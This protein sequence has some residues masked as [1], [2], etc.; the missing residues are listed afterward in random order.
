LLYDVPG[1]DSLK[2]SIHTSDRTNFKRCRQRWDFSSNIR[3]NLEPKK[4]IT[5]LWF[6]TGIHEALAAYYDPTTGEIEY[7]RNGQGILTKSEGRDPDYGIFVF[8]NFVGSWL[9]SLGEPGE[10]QILW[11][12][13]NLELGLG[14]LD[15]YFKWAPKNDDFE[16]I[17]VEREYKVG[18]PGLPGVSYSFRC[19]GLIKTK[20]H[21]WLLEHKTTAQFPDQ[22][23]WLMMDDQCGSY[24]WGLSQLD[25]PIFAEGVV[26]NELKKKTPQPLRPLL[27]GGYSINRSQDTSFDIALTTLRNEY[28]PIPKKYWD[29]L[30]FLKYKP[31]NFI[32]RTPV[33]RNRR[34]I[35]L[36]GEML[37]YEVLDMVNNP[38]IYRSPSRVNCSSCPFV[39]P[40]IL[41]W[42]GGDVQSILGYEF[43]ERESYYGSTYSDKVKES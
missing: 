43:K 42:E 35:E 9:T 15:N 41:R 20:H 13:E 1:G 40:C 32:K 36:L 23:E 11:A 30:D 28:K 8:E 6:G 34:E 14:M 4:P 12:K 39:A 27:A 18:I 10:D 24:L 22:T 21:T 31:D 5:P 38:A 19:D 33:R 37:R 25:P 3:G 16:V 17:W 26:Y 2:I 29:F 7:F